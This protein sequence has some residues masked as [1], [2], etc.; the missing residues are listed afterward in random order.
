M[1]KT[2][3]KFTAIGTVLSHTAHV[4]EFEFEAQPKREIN[5]RHK[6]FDKPKFNY[7]R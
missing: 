7:K 1:S 6:F 3:I 2:H 4:V 5:R